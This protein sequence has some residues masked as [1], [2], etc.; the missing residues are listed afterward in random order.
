MGNSIVEQDTS[1]V[2]LIVE[3]TEHTGRCTAQCEWKINRVSKVDSKGKGINNHEYPLTNLMID[4]V[5]FP[6]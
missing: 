2:V 4:R 5:L 3:L 6:P 1:N